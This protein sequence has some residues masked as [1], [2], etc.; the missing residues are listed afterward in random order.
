[1]PAILHNRML[2]KLYNV[3]CT[4][5]A[6]Q[7][8]QAR[9]PEATLTLAHDGPSRT[10][11]EELGRSLGLRNCRFIGKV[12]QSEIA[13]LYDAH[14]IYITTPNFDC[15]PG[16]LL[17]CYASGIPVV[18]TR[19]GGIPFMAEHEKTAMLVEKD[20]DRGV[21]E[22]VF[23]LLEN[24]EFAA[25]IASH[26]YA[27]LEDYSGERVREQWLALYRELAPG[28]T[29]GRVRTSRPMGESTL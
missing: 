15:L 4:L 3:P 13:E 5:R 29:S 9:Y 26:A 21:A 23:R 10:E 1:M 7:R 2:D 17:E 27:A 8:I 16:S 22:C 18:A 11:L 28:R 19:A 24:P 25:T 14:D 6:F 20:D 12:R